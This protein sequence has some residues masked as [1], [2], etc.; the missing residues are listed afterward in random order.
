MLQ[1]FMPSVLA[2]TPEAQVVVADNGSS[3]GSLAWLEREYPQVRRLALDR[4]YGFAEGYNQALAQVDAEYYVLLNNDVE[5][6]EGWLG[7]LLSYMDLHP[8]V[9][10]CQPKLLCQWKR[11]DFEYAGACGGFV[12]SLG[13]PYCRG[14]LMGTVERDEGQ[15]DM[16]L[17][18]LWATG[19]ALVI[20]S[21]DYHRA[22]GLDG[23]F[24]AHQ[25][26]ID[27]CWRLR[28]RGRGVVCV[29][30]SVV[31]HL[32][33]GTLP[34]DNPRKTFLNF[35]NNLLLLYKNLPPE[36]LAP[37]MRWRLWLDA[38]ASLKF[39]VTGHWGSFRA[40]WQGRRAFYRMR[41]LFEADRRLNLSLSVLSPVPEQEAF[42]LLWQYY[43]RGRRRWSQLRGG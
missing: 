20:R 30:Q 35:R 5:V 22:G 21:A 36:R 38:L 25:E 28:S 41:P 16:V 9:A 43:V 24:F 19:A 31:Y 7:T 40:V 12:D 23:R 26:E 2:C 17:P 8:E 37:V 34:A 4:N 29:P 39:L 3:D 10:A 13:Y 42:S 11:E 33:G 15:Y 32:G 18:V 27:L 1:R 6:T 14:R